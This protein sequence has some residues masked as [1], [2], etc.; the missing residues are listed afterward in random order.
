MPKSK[1]VA[2]PRQVRVDEDV[3]EHLQQIAE[4]Q[5]RSVANLIGVIILEYV[6]RD[7][8]NRRFIEESGQ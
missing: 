2:L 5:H 4:R 3:H 8:S 7:K 6:E 1:Y